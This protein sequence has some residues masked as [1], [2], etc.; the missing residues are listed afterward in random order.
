MCSNL[1]GTYNCTCLSGYR[2]DG[3]SCLGNM[4]IFCT[5]C[6][7]LIRGSLIF[8]FVKCKHCC[9]C[10][11]IILSCHATS[12][13]TWIRI[14]YLIIQILSFVK[15]HHALV[16]FCHIYLYRVVFVINIVPLINIPFS[17]SPQKALFFTVYVVFSHSKTLIF[18]PNIYIKWHTESYFY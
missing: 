10:V 9:K 13:Y 1:D 6:N 18:L 7:S 5:T 17:F 16:K 2:G 3:F 11:K 12:T 14:H 8:Y 15:V 4:I